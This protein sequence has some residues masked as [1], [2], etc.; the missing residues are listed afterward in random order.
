MSEP[1]DSAEQSAA[2][3]A[4]RRRLSAPTRW[5][6]RINHLPDALATVAVAMLIVSVAV[7]VASRWLGISSAWTEEAT[8]Y[9]F[10][11]LVFLGMGIGFRDA[12]SARVSMFVLLLPQPLRRFL[13]VGLYSV[14]SV[15]FFAFLLVQGSGLLIRQFNS[16]QT[17]TALPMP[18]WIVGLAVPV[19][20]V[21][22]ILAVTESLLVH[23]R[24]I[25]G[26]EETEG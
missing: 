17:A 8:R 5:L 20:G 25:E 26:E 4:H 22:G 6:Q 9:F 19:A 2:L 23:R 13:A 24:R 1:R 16:G 15:G 7:Q 14:A 10:I 12:S 3:T 21:V 18:M 11:W